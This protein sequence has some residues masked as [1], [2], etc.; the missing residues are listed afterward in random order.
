[1]F[2]T[3][4]RFFKGL[5]RF[6]HLLFAWISNPHLSLSTRLSYLLSLPIA[7]IRNRMNRRRKINYLGRS[8]VYDSPITPIILLRYPTEISDQII[9]SVQ[10]PLDSV[11]DIGGNIGQFSTT[12]KSLR[13]DISRIDVFEPNPTVFPLLGRNLESLSGVTCYN[14]GIGPAGTAQFHFTPGYSGIGSLVS[15]NARYRSSSELKTVDVKLVSDIAAVTGQHSYDL[16]KIDVE[17]FE[18]EVLEAL[19]NVRFRYLYVEIT[20]PA[21][22]KSHLTSEIYTLIS[23]R[24]G[25]F[26]V[27]YQGT[28]TPDST[29]FEA[30]FEFPSAASVAQGQDI[31]TPVSVAS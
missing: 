26:E 20:G 31:K 13:P 29:V 27:K 21:K 5:T 28:C 9:A 8:F 19:E 24:F 10:G 25:P 1:M 11:L 30:M 22:S 4:R 18:Y 17:G 3:V 16:V 12:L 23:Q 14:Y 2:H 6:G 7:L 15:N